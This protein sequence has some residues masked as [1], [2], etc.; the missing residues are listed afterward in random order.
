MGEECHQ[1][2]HTVVGVCSSVHHKLT[3]CSHQLFFSLA[4]GSYI[5]TYQMFFVPGIPKFFHHNIDNMS[6]YFVK[7]ALGA[8]ETVDFAGADGV[9]GTIK[10][11]VLASLPTCQRA[12]APCHPPDDQ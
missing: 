7:A 1:V 4:R 9:C 11:D 8:W 2:L 3:T 10:A 6:L 12:A 5:E